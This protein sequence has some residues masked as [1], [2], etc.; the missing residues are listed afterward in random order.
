MLSL[1]WWLIVGL[2]ADAVARLIIAP[3]DEQTVR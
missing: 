3:T 1:L 2:V